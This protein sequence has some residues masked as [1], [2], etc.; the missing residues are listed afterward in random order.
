MSLQEAAPLVVRNEGMMGEPELQPLRGSPRQVI[1][2]NDI[3]Q[4]TIDALLRRFALAHLPGAPP[5]LVERLRPVAIRVVNE[6][7]TEA[8]L[9]INPIVGVRLEDHFWTSFE[10]ACLRFIQ[11][12]MKRERPEQHEGEQA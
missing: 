5:A 6:Y 12:E 2:A 3:R 11:A 4:R 9:W 8:R 10:F 7:P 1:W